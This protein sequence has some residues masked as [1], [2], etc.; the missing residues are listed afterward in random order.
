MISSVKILSDTR[1]LNIQR[2]TNYRLQAEIFLTFLLKFVTKLSFY[3]NA[4]LLISL[5]RQR[6]WIEIVKKVFLNVSDC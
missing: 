4:F 3:G 5:V 2:Y 6:N 1:P